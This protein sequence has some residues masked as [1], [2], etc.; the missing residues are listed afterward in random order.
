MSDVVLVHAGIA[1]SR[2]WEPQLESFSTEHRVHTF[3]LPGFGEEPLVPGGLSYVD[4]V[5]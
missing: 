5:A 1:D 4:W 3:D 2:M